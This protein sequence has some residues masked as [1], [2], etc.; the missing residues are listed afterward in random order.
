M[1]RKKIAA[2]VVFG[3]TMTTCASPA[4]G[5][6]TPIKIEK[7]ASGN[8]VA[9]IEEQAKAQARMDV[10]YKNSMG[11]KNAL[12]SLNHYVGKTWYVFSGAS[13]SGWD[14]SGLVVWFYEQQG[15]TLEH[16]ASKQDTAGTETDDPKPGDIVVFKYK[17]YNDAYHVGVYIGNG[18]MIHAP[19]HGHLTRIEDI[20]TFGGKYSN[21]TYRHIID[22]I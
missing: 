2:I 7:P 16:R 9:S 15:I 17:G 10:L 3:L 20:S 19:K 4:A 21:V 6:T 14:C 22:T 1:Y 13:P 8:L 12:K 18:M 5:V 11:M